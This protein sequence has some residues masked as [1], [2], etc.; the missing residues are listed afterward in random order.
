MTVDEILTERAI[1]LL[2]FG[3]KKLRYE[4]RICDR[5]MRAKYD[6]LITKTAQAAYAGEIE[7]AAASLALAI[8][9]HPDELIAEMCARADL[10]TY[11]YEQTMLTTNAAFEAMQN[12]RPTNR[13]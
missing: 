2:E 11:L 12:S 8:H 4:M 13:S 10:I 7:D 5:R 9:A 3:I 6:K 1:E